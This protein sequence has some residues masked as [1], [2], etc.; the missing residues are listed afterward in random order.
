MVSESGGGTALVEEAAVASDGARVAEATG[1]SAD[2]EP[3][4]G[5]AG[6]GG[7]EAGA[8]SCGEMGGAAEGSSE[9]SA[10]TRVTMTDAPASGLMPPASAR[11]SSKVTWR[12]A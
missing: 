2:L 6:S 10:S 3:A 5:A 12:S 7:R 1:E 8:A 4:E 11:T 9:E